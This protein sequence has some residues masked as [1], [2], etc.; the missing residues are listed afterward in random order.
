MLQKVITNLHDDDGVQIAFQKLLSALVSERDYSAQEVSHILLGCPLV[1]SSRSYQSLS[2]SPDISQP[3]DFENPT[4][5]V[6]SLVEHYC[7]RPGLED[8]SLWDFSCKWDY[9]GGTYKE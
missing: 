3:L 8:L 2:V 1:V 7:N 4:H 5:E 9:K 6:R